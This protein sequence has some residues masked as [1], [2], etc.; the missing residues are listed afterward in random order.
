MEDIKCTVPQLLR[1]FTCRIGWA[2]AVSAVCCM[3]S[4]CCPVLG[5]I[6]ADERKRYALLETEQEH[7]L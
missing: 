7:F 6:T 2:Y 4:I 5:K 1:S 3:L